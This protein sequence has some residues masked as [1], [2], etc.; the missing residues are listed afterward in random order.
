MGDKISQ[1]P[2][3]T[4]VDGTELVPIVQGGD[5]KQVTGAILRSPTGIAGGDLTGTYPN[6]TLGAITTAQIAVGSSTQVPV[7]S[8]DAKGRVT[9]LSSVPVSAS[10]SA[11]TSLT[12]DVTATGPGAAAAT[13]AAITTA[14]INVGSSTSVPVLSIDDKGRVTA[15][16]SA[17]IS[18]TAG[19]TVT[20]ITAGTGL[21][22]GTITGSGTIEL[23]SLTTAQSNV[24]SSTEVPVLSINDQGQVVGLSTVPISAGGSLTTS[25]PADLSATAVVGIGTTAARSDHQHAFPTAAQVGALGAT[26]AAGGDLTGNF[27]NPTLAAITT[28]QSNV[29]SS[30]AIPV[31]SVDAKGRVIG[32]TTALNAASGPAGGD[33]TGTFPNPTLASITSSQTVGSSTQVPI[34]TVDTKG[35]VTNLTSVTVSGGGGATPIPVT[36][37]TVAGGGGATV[38]GGGAG[39]L[40][41]LPFTMTSGVTYTIVVGAGGTGAVYTGTATAGTNSTISS[42]S[43]TY[44]TAIGGGRGGIGVASGTGGAGG[45]GGSGGGGGWGT[46][47]SSAGGAGTSGQGFN[48]ANGTAGTS[49]GGGGGS[50]AAGTSGSVPNGGAGASSSIT[51][52][53]VNYAGGGAGGT[54]GATNPT[55]GVG[56]GGNGGSGSTPTNTTSGSINTGG[57]GGGSTTSGVGGNGGSGV[58]IL[59]IPLANYTGLVTGSP[60]ITTSGSNAIVKFTSSGTYIA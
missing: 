9:S 18:G 1:L 59:S 21:S 13:L 20:S 58:V 4:T 19:G 49:G 30:S 27:P 23:A 2:V 44:A 28:A 26:A 6:P 29:G 5:T 46:S 57:G 14:Q 38:G 31:L 56:G 40:I 34:I 41:A 55:G 7:L 12:G 53:A 8:I 43:Y 10:G 48:G 39:G 22:G 50:A 52:S 36:S 42:P 51:G 24:G 45:A 17:P 37:L 11:I 25:A 32:L 3:A 60:T 16:G 54:A 35:R 47:G 15:L 33:L